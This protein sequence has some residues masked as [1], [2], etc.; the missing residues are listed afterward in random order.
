MSV[1]SLVPPYRMQA[2]LDAA[3]DAFPAELPAEK[4]RAICDPLNPCPDR[5]RRRLGRHQ[6]RP[7]RCWQ[8]SRW[9]VVVR[10]TSYPCPEGFWVW[11][12]AEFRMAHSIREDSR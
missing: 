11:V 12:R 7:W 8:C 6:E 10:R 4:Q 1:N 5:P 2:F 9:W 3:D